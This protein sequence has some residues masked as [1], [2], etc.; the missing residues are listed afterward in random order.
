MAVSLFFSLI[1][2]QDNRTKLVSRQCLW[3][4]SLWLMDIQQSIFNCCIL[5]C[6]MTVHNRLAKENSLRKLLRSMNLLPLL[7][8]CNFWKSFFKSKIW[9]TLCFLEQLRIE[10]LL[11]FFLFSVL[12]P[13]LYSHFLVFHHN[14]TR[15]KDLIK[16]WRSRV[17]KYTNF[18]DQNSFRQIYKICI[19]L[20]S[21]NVWYW[22]EWII[23]VYSL[24]F[25]YSFSQKEEDFE[26]VKRTVARAN[27]FMSRPW[28]SY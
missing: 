22:L 3:L 6:F 27:L 16:Y 8:L 26:V 15:K 10:I 28:C 25:K 19:F 7:Y 1:Y 24:S 11:F 4:R 9:G 2:G 21:T 20:L 12:S 13:F 17:F 18:S 5:Y 14:L 23:S